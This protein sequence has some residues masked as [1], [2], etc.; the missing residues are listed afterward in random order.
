MKKIDGRSVRHFAKAACEV[1]VCGVLIAASF[2]KTK[3]ERTRPV[4]YD[5][6]VD[7]IMSSSMLGSD[8][9]EA[10]KLLKH[11]ADND[12]Y[13]AVISIVRSSMLG[14][15]KVDMIRYLSEK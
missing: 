9:C 10:V 6:A 8:R 14:S 12:Y 4:G 13:G 15:D 3:G 2:A 1:V 7:A 11:G 5:T